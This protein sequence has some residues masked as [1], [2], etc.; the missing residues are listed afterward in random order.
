MDKRLIKFVF[1]ELYLNDELVQL[2]RGQGWHDGDRLAIGD[3]EIPDRDIRYFRNSGNELHVGWDDVD[4]GPRVASMIMDAD[5]SE[6][7]A[8]INYS[9]SRRE[10]D[11]RLEQAAEQGLG[12]RCRDSVCPHCSARIFSLDTY[13]WSPQVYCK[14]CDSLCTMT[15]KSLPS[16]DKLNENEYRTCP[17]CQMYSRPREFTI[18]YFWFIIFH[19][20]VTHRTVQ[21]CNDCMKPETW[22]MVFG[23][24]P[25]L[26]GMPLAITQWLRVRRD[27]IKAGPF[28]GL[29]EANR[30]L[31]RGKVEHALDKYWKIVERHPVSAG[32]LYNVAKGLLAQDDRQHALETLEL[33]LEYCPNYPPVVVLLEQH[34]GQIA[35][36]PNF[37]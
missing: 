8:A 10:F 4:Q 7:V 27:S 31:K 30:L 21:C 28:Q 26:L 34:F 16:L 29:D 18:G 9:L 19:A 13:P 12:T 3:L 22:K 11:Q 15:D 35:Q 25:G 23:N 36:D 33:A 17:R 6:I 20:G 5:S 2:E 1:R 14:W 37:D 32:V 24:L